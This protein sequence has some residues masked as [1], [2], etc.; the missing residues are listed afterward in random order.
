MDDWSP[1]N[2]KADDQPVFQQVRTQLQQIHDIAAKVDALQK[3]AEERV[4]GKGKVWL[5]TEGFRDEMHKQSFDILEALHKEQIQTAAN[6]KTFEFN[7]LHAVYQQARNDLRT[8]YA[9]L[10]RQDDAKIEE[11]T[12]RYEL[13]KGGPRPRTCSSGKLSRNGAE[14]ECSGTPSLTRVRSGR[15]GGRQNRSRG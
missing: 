10:M 12:Q 5:G 2:I 3:E 7:R 13:E 14:A 4:Y 9:D 6:R 11:I 8:K 15:S 1:T